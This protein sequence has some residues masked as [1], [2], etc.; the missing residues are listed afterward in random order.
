MVYRLSVCCQLRLGMPA[1]RLVQ[2][3]DQ[4]RLIL[5]QKARLR[6][7][8]DRVLANQVTGIR[9]KEIIV[10]Y[11]LIFPQWDTPADKLKKIE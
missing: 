2:L 11:T 3:P 8:L 10:R 1:A 4:S 9:N 7:V 6:P 5:G